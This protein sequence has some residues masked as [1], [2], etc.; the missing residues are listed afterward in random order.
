MAGE[1]QFIGYLHINRSFVYNNQN[2]QGEAD[3]QNN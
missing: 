3:G 1:A 2:I